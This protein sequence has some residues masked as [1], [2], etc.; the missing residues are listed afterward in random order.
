MLSDHI[1]TLSVDNWTSAADFVKT[2][3]QNKAALIQYR[4]TVLNKWAEWKEEIKQRCAKILALD[5]KA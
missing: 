2:L 4:T 3:L 5:A 1:T